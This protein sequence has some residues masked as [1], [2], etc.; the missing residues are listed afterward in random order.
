[1]YILGRIPES[2]VRLGLGVFDGFHLGHQQIAA[3]ADALL[4]FVP[5]PDH[6][7]KKHIPLQYI[8]TVKEQFKAI[9]HLLGVRFTSEL[10]KW[11]YDTF[12]ETLCNKIPVSGLVIGE[13]FCC[14]SRREG[15][16]ERLRDWAKTRRLSLH[17]EPLLS[18]QGIVVKSATIRQTLLEGNVEQAEAL[19]GRPYVLSGHV[20]PGHGIGKTLGF[21][22]ANLQISRFKLLPKPGVYGGYCDHLGTRWTTAL[23]IGYRPTFG[24]QPLSV[25][26]HLITDAG[27][28]LV[29]DLY[30]QHLSIHICTRIREEMRF[31]T[32]EALIRQIQKD[33]EAI[34]QWHSPKHI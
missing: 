5:H 9:P 33:K 16:P 19:L 32:R 8:D 31:E 4:T 17:V 21:P 1:M 12:L 30:G 34:A 2:P 15:T 27:A 29:P 22:T 11:P 10:A 14:G 20:I 6:V 25:E 7:L 28:P 13:D 24:K 3:H 23:Y 26:A 18:H